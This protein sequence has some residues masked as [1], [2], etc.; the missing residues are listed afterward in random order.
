MDDAHITAINKLAAKLEKRRSAEE[1]QTVRQRKQQLNDRY[2]HTCFTLILHP[3]FKFY[4]NSSFIIE[5][6]AFLKAS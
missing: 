1:L 5:S 4:F 3:L 2:T 6:N